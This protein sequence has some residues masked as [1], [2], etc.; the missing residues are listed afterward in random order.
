MKMEE[1]LIQKKFYETLVNNNEKPQIE[2]LGEIFIEEQ[3]KDIPNLTEIRYAQGEVYFHNRDY[4]AA[5]FKWENINGKLRPWAQKNMADAYFELELYETAESIYQSIETENHVLKV[6]VYLQLFSLYIIESK[7]ELATKVIKEAVDFQPDY[8]NVTKMACAFFE[9][10]RDWSKAI[11]LAVNESI[12]TKSLV[13]FDLLKD[14][15][16]QGKTQSVVPH[17][18]VI[19]L[20]SLCQLDQVRF[21]K[22]AVALWKN[23]KYTDLYFEWLTV[24]TALIK[25]MENQKDS[26]KKL[27]HQYEET[28]THLL[29][30]KYVLQELKSII[31]SLLENWL[32]I[33]RGE[34]ALFAAAA[35][36]S[37]NEVFPEM[38]NMLVL[39]DAE[40]I[41]RD[42]SKVKGN[43]D[44]CE[45]LFMSLVRWAESH[46]VPV[47]NKL[48]WFVDELVNEQSYLLCLLEV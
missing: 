38:M 13:W 37:C 4:E 24:I 40:N 28:F 14:Y 46:D 8:P 17:D 11:E 7:D 20:R 5:I 48:K 29:E 44:A 35:V 16:E 10:Q 34:Q 32:K 12:R 30:G 47:S 36:S 31:P 27:S 6:E 1:Q 45:K 26:W 41:L 2:S 42:S 43:L 21:E 22:M 18:F 39:Q 3:K 33:S 19:I 23:Y 25:E 15:V 9:G